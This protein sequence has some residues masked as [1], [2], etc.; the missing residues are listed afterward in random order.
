MAKKKDTMPTSAQGKFSFKGG[1]TLDPWIIDRHEVSPELIPKESVSRNITEELK[2]NLR[3]YP[4]PNLFFL[5]FSN[6]GTRFLLRVVVCNIPK[7][8]KFWNVKIN[9]FD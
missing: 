2:K 7:F 6:L 4:K 9:K 1:S 3:G 5:A 8:S